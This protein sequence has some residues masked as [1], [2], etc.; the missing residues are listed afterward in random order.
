MQNSQSQTETVRMLKLRDVISK[1]QI[2]RSTIYDKLDHKSKRHDPNF[3]KPRKLGMNSV[4]WVEH[5]VERWL[6]NLPCH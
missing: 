6:Q 5:E 4:A 3:P 2:S 1:C